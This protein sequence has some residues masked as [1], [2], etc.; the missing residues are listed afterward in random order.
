MMRAFFH[1]VRNG[2]CTVRLV[3]STHQFQK[4]IQTVF[5][6]FYLGTELVRHDL[7]EQSHPAFLIERSVHQAQLSVSFENRCVQLSSRLSVLLSV[8][9]VRVVESPSP[10]LVIVSLCVQQSWIGRIEHTRVSV[11]REVPVVKVFARGV[12]FFFFRICRSGCFSWYLCS[13]IKFN[14]SVRWPGI[15]FSTTRVMHGFSFL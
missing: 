10:L 5:H 4:F 1:L 7:H 11:E 9:A 13:H 3:V 2:I 6:V 12:R 8:S 14:D 15:Q